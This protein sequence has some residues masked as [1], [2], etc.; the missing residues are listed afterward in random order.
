MPFWIL[1]QRNV[2]PQFS[3]K[4]TLFCFYIRESLLGCGLYLNGL[5]KI[6]TKLQSD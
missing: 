1:L 5:K 6:K 4:M 3:V 2:F